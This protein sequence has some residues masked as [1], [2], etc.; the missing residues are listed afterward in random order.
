MK[1][2]NRSNWAGLA[3]NGIGQ[4]KPNQYLEMAK[5][6]WRNRDQ[7][8]FAWRILTRGVC[9]GCALGTAG[10]RDFTMDGVH[11]CMVRLELMRLNTAPSLDIK[12]LEDAA[13]L[14]RM[15]AAELRELG[16]LP[17]PMRRRRGE[18]GFTR[19]AWEEALNIAA[20][21]AAAAQPQRMAF[22]L[23]SRGLTN[24]AYY[25]AQK[26]ARFFGTNNIDNSARICHAPSTVALKQTIG[27]AA[28]TCSYKDWI[29]SDLLVFWGSNTPNNQPVTTKYMHYAKKAGTRIA[30]VDP[31]R[32]YGLE[33]YRSPSAITSA[34]FGSRRLDEFFQL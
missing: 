28:S 27:A 25:V 9:D 30:V 29:G 33:R 26:V 6:L 3:P 7:L 2:W 17:Y 23:T 34:L 19:V 31:M 18:K 8:P 21:A 10:V 5:V 16:R 20:S 11:L 1:K 32:E 15:T 24:E 12:R 13:P 4:V 22:Y 14:A